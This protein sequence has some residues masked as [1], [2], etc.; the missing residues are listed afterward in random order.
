M[1]IILIFKTVEENMDG[2]GK[3]S[4]IL[5]IAKDGVSL[6]ILRENMYIISQLSG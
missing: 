5:R 4:Q 6:K 3:D 1:S 2:S